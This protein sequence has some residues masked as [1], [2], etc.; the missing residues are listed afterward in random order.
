M[1]GQRRLG[2]LR[3]IFGT[4]MEKGTGNWRKLHNEELPIKSQKLAT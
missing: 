2:V 1:E 3:K 4:K